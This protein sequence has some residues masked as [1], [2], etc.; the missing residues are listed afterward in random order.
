M[1]KYTIE[2]IDNYL[3]IRNQG[4]KEIAVAKDA[5]PGYIEVDG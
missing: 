2:E 4:G 1:K 5:E 3:L